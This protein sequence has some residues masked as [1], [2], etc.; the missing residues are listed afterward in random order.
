MFRRSPKVA[1]LLATYDGCRFLEQQLNSFE[2]QTYTKW[3]LW[4]SDDGSKDHTLETLQAYGKIW[5]KGKLSVVAGPGKGFATNFMSLVCNVGTDADYFAFA[6]Q[7]DDWEAVKL[8]RAVDWLETIPANVPALYCSRTRLIDEKN[9]DMGMSP[10]FLRPPTFG[11]ALTQNIAGGNTMIFNRAARELLQNIGEDV[12]IVAHDWLAY[13][14][15]TACGGV[16]YYDHYPSVKYRQHER[17]VLGANRS[18]LDR[19]RRIKMLLRGTY[20]SWITL[21]INALMRIQNKLTTRNYDMLVSFARARN[22][23]PIKQM[24]IMKKYQIHR[25]TFVDNMGLILAV[26]LRKF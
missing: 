15:V 24:L 12:S 14:V 20:K 16:V 9:N 26:I 21:N 25:Q 19:A 22:S 8:E 13:L 10:L 4:A 5:P 11:N 2:K 6:D 1:I 18:W 17:N 3:E 7:D 23:N